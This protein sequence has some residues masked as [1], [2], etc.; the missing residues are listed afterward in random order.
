MPCKHSVQID[1][2]DYKM[3]IFKSITLFKAHLTNQ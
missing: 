2:V 1:K 3:D